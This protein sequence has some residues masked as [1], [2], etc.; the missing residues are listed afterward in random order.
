M[1][2]VLVA[3]LDETVASVH[4]S[5]ALQTCV[6]HSSGHAL[7]VRLFAPVGPLRIVESLGAE[8]LTVENLRLRVNVVLNLRLVRQI[9]RVFTDRE[10]VILDRILRIRL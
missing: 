6:F 8:E 4:Q 2:L 10:I 3:P 1:V 9:V 7:G 5:V